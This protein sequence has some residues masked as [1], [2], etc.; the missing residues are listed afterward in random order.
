MGTFDDLVEDVL[1]H[2]HTDGCPEIDRHA[3]D[4]AERQLR[5]LLRACDAVLDA[6]PPGLSAAELTARVQARCPDVS[7]PFTV[8]EVEVDC[9][10]EPVHSLA[11]G[12][13]RSDPG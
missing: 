1:A 9:D 8:A 13:H 4:D 10:G 12:Y 7:I 11:I 6:A 3:R 2:R 5:C